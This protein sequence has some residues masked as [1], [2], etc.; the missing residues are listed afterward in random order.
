MA[1][2]KFKIGFSPCPNDTFIFDALVNGKID[3]GEFE[4]EPVLEDVQT[5]NQWALEKKLPVTKLSFGVFPKVL[6]NYVLLNSG[7]AL[8]RGVGPL[9]ISDS[10]MPGLMATETIAVPGGDTTAN[11]LFSLAYP[12][13]VHKIF[14]RYDMIEDYVLE[15]KGPGVIIHENRFTY[16]EKGLYKIR[17]LGEY[18]EDKTQHPIPLGGIVIDRLLP[19]SVQHS[20][21]RLIRQSIEYAYAAYPKLSGYV[22]THAQEMEESVMRKHIDL[23]VNQFSID[24]GIEGKNAIKKLMDVY[25]SINGLEP[26]EL[27]PFIL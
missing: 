5:L 3:T 22:K 21:D 27:S 10:V 20:I 7:A 17:D 6:N 2:R 16:Q 14:L 23:Y 26:G 8:G 4:F 13:A 1:T 9:L 15:G 24:L 18:W 11:L 25:N 19:I 12:E